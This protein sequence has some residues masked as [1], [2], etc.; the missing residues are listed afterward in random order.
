MSPGDAEYDLTSARAYVDV[1]WDFAQIRDPQ[2]PKAD[3]SST[4]FQ[5][6]AVSIPF[7]GW[8]C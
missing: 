1:R 2:S 5:V 4:N 6:R 7:T 3:F 8:P